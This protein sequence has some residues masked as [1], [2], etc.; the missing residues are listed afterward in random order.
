MR[1][2]GHVA[3]ERD[4]NAYNILIGKRKG[5]RPLGERRRR[6]KDIIKINLRELVFQTVD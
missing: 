1:Y 2:V 3:R 6:G 5:K 4:E